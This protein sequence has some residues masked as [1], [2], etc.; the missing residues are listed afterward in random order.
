MAL[1]VTQS[2]A[3]SVLV[4]WQAPADGFRN[5]N[6]TYY[7]VTIALLSFCSKLLSILIIKIQCF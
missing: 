6:V 3:T 5:G 7:Q 4:A 1:T 2:N